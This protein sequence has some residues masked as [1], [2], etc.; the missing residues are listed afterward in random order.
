M[1]TTVEKFIP[2][3]FQYYREPTPKKTEWEK[4]LKQISAMGFNTLKY[5]VQ[6]RTSH[7][8]PGV[9]KFDDIQELMDLAHKYG[10]KVILNVI[11]DVAPVWFYKMH[12]E[13]KMITA[14]G[15]VLEPVALCLRQVGGAPGPCYHHDEANRYKDEFLRETVKRFK[16]HPAMLI[17]DLWNEPE[18]TTCIKREPRYE[19]LVCY[20]EN[21][22]NKFAVW[23]EKKYGG[24]AALN[25]KWQRSY[26]DWSEVEAPRF[27][28]TFN[29]MIDWRLF[30]RDTLTDELKRRVEAVKSLDLRNPVMCHTVP[31]PI[32]NIV[33]CGSDDFE[34]AKLCD[35]FGNSLG[36]SSWNSDLLMSV[37]NGK[38]AIN[39]EIHAVPGSTALKPRKLKWKEL[40]KHILVP[41]A[42]G[43]TG[44]VFWQYRPE[45]LGLEAPA[46]GMT[47]MDGSKTQW[48][49]NT[50]R[51]NDIIQENL[52]AIVSGGITDD[53]MAI[54][55]NT[56]CQIANF[57]V[58][59]HLDTYSNSVQG[60]H[61]ILHDLNYKVSFIHEMDLDAEK[62]SRIKCLWL[63]YPLYMSGEMCKTL[64]N[65]VEAGGVL[66]SECSFGM[67]EAEQGLHSMVVPGYGFDRVFGVREK[68]IQSYDNMDNSYHDIETG[69]LVNQLGIVCQGEGGKSDGVIFGSYLQSE[70]EITENSRVLARFEADGSP[71]ITCSDYGKGKAVWIGTLLGAAYWAQTEYETLRL[72]GKVVS[73]FGI[74]PSFQSE[75]AGVRVDALVYTTETGS[76]ALVTVENC[77][78]KPIDTAIVSRDG[79]AGIN[80]LWFNE[81]EVSV[82]DSKLR[83]RLE[84]QDIH[85]VDCRLGIG[86]IA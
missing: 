4:D 53:G 83:I 5:L 10:L 46:W 64:K 40:K 17:W 7:L 18:L 22:L 76:N 9:F 79:I 38:K 49:E 69:R 62:L 31:F 2:F 71:A 21:S 43:I 68:W 44:F 33:S 80:S 47:Y 13:S 85:V 6:W 32:F 1:Y 61:K 63:P 52:G 3:G 20:C 39:S 72:V 15:H 70:A 35:M 41:L 14:D 57:A 73:D 58:Y 19:E 67:I 16:D 30:F 37:A 65:W 23:L 86:T 36:S 55:L 45:I 82:I 25:D 8:E 54:L 28:A 74:K 11:F 26:R 51:L 78:D 84:P 42:R 77:T 75:E 48:L 60:I 27:Q 34:L 29:D 59:K 50:A 56:G 12:P 81:T 24:I 66:I